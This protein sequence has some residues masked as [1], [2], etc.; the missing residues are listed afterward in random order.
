MSLYYCKLKTKVA[1]LLLTYTIMI[2]SLKFFKK[3]SLVVVVVS[4]VKRITRYVGLKDLAKWCG[5]TST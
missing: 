4:H 5:S 3:S 1:Q 2:Q